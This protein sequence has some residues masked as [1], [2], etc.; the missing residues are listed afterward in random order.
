MSEIVSKPAVTN[1][2]LDDLVRNRWSPRIYDKTH[3]LSQL[4][5]ESLGEAFRWAPSSMN[6]QPWKLVILTRGSELH[7]QISQE[8]LGGFNGA[9]APNASAL[10]IVL[11]AKRKPTG[12]ELN[13]VGTAYDLGLA[14]M[15]LIMQAE[16]MGLKAHVMGGIN[17]N[18]IGEILGATDHFVMVA[19]TVG[20]QASLEGQEEAI[21]AREKSPRERKA[22]AYLIDQKL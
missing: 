4:E 19:I 12:E 22:D 14:S 9:W 7:N 21:I 18:R 13:Q 2:Q 11:G 15:K 10:A 20:K 3:K 17:H 1:A 8:A 6:A 16:S 5:L